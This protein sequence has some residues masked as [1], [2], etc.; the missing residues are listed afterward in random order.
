MP[1]GEGTALR[2]RGEIGAEPLLLRPAGMPVDVAVQDDDV[3]IA[4]VVAVVPLVPVRGSHAEIGEVPLRG[5]RQVVVIPGRGTSPLPVTAPG[6]LVAPRVFG[7]CAVLIGVVAER[8]HGA[9]NAV[10]Q[11]GG[12]LVVG[13][14]GI[15]ARDIAGAHEHLRC[16]GRLD[17]HRDRLRSRF[18]ISL[19]DGHGRDVISRRRVHVGRRYR[20]PQRGDV[21]GVDAA[22]APVDLVRPRPTSLG[23]VACPE[24]ERDGGT[25]VRAQIGP[26]IYH[27]RK[28]GRVTAF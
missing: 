6:G 2:A 8:E 24:R 3:P 17:Q 5:R 18:T 27:Q 25:G 28:V 9:W 22:I 19:G 14:G 26:R 13:V 4:E 12:P 1:V 10:K 23:R 11:L 21:P 15:T 16:T 7:R 20:L